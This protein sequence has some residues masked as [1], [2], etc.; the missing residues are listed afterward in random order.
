MSA[1][2]RG[3]AEPPAGG[4]TRSAAKMRAMGITT[5]STR[6]GVTTLGIAA[7]MVVVPTASAGYTSS[8]SAISPAQSKAMTPSVWRKGCPVELAALRAVRVNHRTFRG[9]EATG[10]IVVHQDVA[11][12]VAR[13]F[14]SLYRD[15][16]PVRRIQPI[17]KYKG[18]D[19]ASIEADNTSAFNCRKATGSGRWS[20]HAY[21]KAIDINPIEN[22]WVEPGGVVYHTASR[23]FVKRTPR[24]G[25]AVEGGALVRAFD[26]EGWKWGGRWSG[27]KDY[28]H[29]S[30]DGR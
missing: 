22:P 29:F 23:P 7:I 25:M 15:G 19:F 14:R 9:G 26:R 13:I 2:P 16:V 27:T 20:N 4:I 10:T 24:R 30:S 3:A 5:A 8:I 12:A 21:G 6:L 11:P 28:Q 17:E 18:S 1:A